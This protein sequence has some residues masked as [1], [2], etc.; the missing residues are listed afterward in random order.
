MCAYARVRVQVMEE[1]GGREDE[2]MGEGGAKNGPF[3]PVVADFCGGRARRKR[4]DLRTAFVRPRCALPTDRR[5]KPRCGERP[6]K[7]SR[8]TMW[9]TFFS[10][11]LPHE[12]IRTNVGHNESLWEKS[13]QSP[14][15][16]VGWE[17]RPLRSTLPPRLPRSRKKCSSWTATLRPMRRAASES[18]SA[19][20]NRRSTNR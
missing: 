2:K 14:T 18:M 8:E 3:G 16:R 12:P 10:L 13:S 17:K 6:Q 1:E 9:N 15:K 5:G 11:S 20:S 19:K 7:K 4:R